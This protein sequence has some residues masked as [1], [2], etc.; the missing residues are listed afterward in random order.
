MTSSILFFAAALF[1]AVATGLLRKASLR[2]QTELPGAPKSASPVTAF[3]RDHDEPCDGLS[4][5]A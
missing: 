4:H 2:P 1:L 5:A 3:G